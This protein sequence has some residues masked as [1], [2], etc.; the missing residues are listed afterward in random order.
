MQ[1]EWLISF[2]GRNP[3][4]TFNQ[5]FLWKHG[6][7]YVMDNHRAALWCWLRHLS[8]NHKYNLFHIDRHT[9]TLYS[10]IEKWK[11]QVGDVRN[12]SIHEHLNLTYSVDGIECPLIR[13][14]NYLSIFLER[15]HKL[16]NDLVFATD[17]KGDKP[18]F[19]RLDCISIWNIP[20]N[21]ER[22]LA[23]SDY[24]WIFNLDFDYFYCDYEDSHMIMFSDHYIQTI[25]RAISKKY[26]DGKIAVLTVSLSPEFSGGWV[27]AEQMLQTFC[28]IMGLDFALPS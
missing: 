5:N 10:Q 12:Q 13:Y 3:S 25:F 19:E 9:D 11:E 23:E 15:Y 21:L 4:G 26:Q 18:R 7:I 6:A 17:L 16:I 2:K 22:W 24:Q 1:G 20:D 14:D 27:S 28:S 8:E